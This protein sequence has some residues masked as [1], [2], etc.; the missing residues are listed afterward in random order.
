[1]ATK[2]HRITEGV[3]GEEVI[4]QFRAALA[5]NTKSYEQSDIEVLADLYA[6]TP[7]DNFIVNDV[8]ALSNPCIQGDIILLNERCEYY[9][10][11]MES[12][13]NLKETDNRNLQEGGVASL[14]H[15]IEVLEG[16]NLKIENG[17]FIPIDNLTRGSYYSCKVITSDKPFLLNHAEHGNM[18]LPAGK[19]MAYT[20]IDPKT[21]Q[22]VID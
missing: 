6:K 21:F 9:A 12:V 19:Y 15:R 8:E 16:T 2:I 14:N 7:T 11:Q 22:R 4:S 20:A 1:M 5:D 17:R 10:K 3:T 18:S 13:T